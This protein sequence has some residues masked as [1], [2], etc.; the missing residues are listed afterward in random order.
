MWFAGSSRGSRLPEEGSNPDELV[1][2][3]A[4]DQ[5][6]HFQ[7]AERGHDL[8][9]VRP[10]RAIRS[11]TAV[12]LVV[13]LAQE[14]AFRVGE[15]QLGGV[16][17]RRLAGSGADFAGPGGRAPRG[18]R[19]RS[20]PGGRRRGSGDGSRGWTG[21]RP[22]R[23]RRRPRGSAR[24]RAARSRA[25]RCAGV[26]ST[27]TTPRRQPRD[28]AVALR[29]Q[30]GQR[31]LPHRHLADQGPGLDQGAGQVLVLGGIDRGQPVGQDGDRCGRPP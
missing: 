1:P 3:Q 20:R 30:T 22:G 23:E 19:R 15:G 25:S 13:E 7:D 28:D 9:A 26:A 11:S 16:A 27:T 17:D 14:R 31:D 8:R 5:P 24:W 21:C 6:F 10:V 4:A 18:C 12:G 29:E 2:G